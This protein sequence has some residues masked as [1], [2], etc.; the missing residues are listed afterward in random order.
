M[1]S[2]TVKSQNG[3]SVPLKTRL[4]LDIIKHVGGQQV[5]VPVTYKEEIFV[6]DFV[7][8]IERSNEFRD[9]SEQALKDMVSLYFEAAVTARLSGDSVA[10]ALSQSDEFTSIFE[11]MSVRDFMSDR[12]YEAAKAKNGG[13]S[14]SDDEI[15]NN[16]IVNRL[17]MAAAKFLEKPLQSTLFK[18]TLTN[19]E[20]K[21]ESLDQP[22]KFASVVET[23]R[24]AQRLYSMLAQREPLE[25]IGTQCM[26]TRKDDEVLAYIDA[27]RTVFHTGDGAVLPMNYSYVLNEFL[28]V[29]T[30]AAGRRKES[31]RPFLDLEPLSE[32]GIGH[33]YANLKGSSLVDDIPY[34]DLLYAY[35]TLTQMFRGFSIHQLKSGALSIEKLIRTVQYNSGA[36]SPSIDTS[37]F[38]LFMSDDKVTLQE[39]FLMKWFKF[40]L[41]ERII[42]NKPGTIAARFFNNFEM[43]RFKREDAFSGQIT[44]TTAIVGMFYDSLVDTLSFVR[45]ILLDESLFFEDL[46]PQHGPRIRAKIVEMDSLY[47]SLTYGADH[48]KHLMD[49]ALPFETMNLT[50]FDEDQFKIGGYLPSFTLDSGQY[51]KCLTIRDPKTWSVENWWRTSVLRGFTSD[52]SIGEIPFRFLSQVPTFRPTYYVSVPRPSDVMTEPM[53]VKFL[54]FLPLNDVLKSE[55]KE[56]LI[57][58]GEVILLSNHRDAAIKL[59]ISHVLAARILGPN[60]HTVFKLRDVSE[61]VILLA[62]SDYPVYE[63][64]LMPSIWKDA[65]PNPNNHFVALYPFVLQ[66]DYAGSSKGFDNPVTPS[67]GQRLSDI[68]MTKDSEVDESLNKPAP[69]DSKVEEAKDVKVDDKPTVDDEVDLMSKDDVEESDDDKKK[70]KS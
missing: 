9:F 36:M 47:N 25:T 63:T 58:R 42:K 26:T 1:R 51:A 53:I 44:E 52:A 19:R 31:K 27:V 55:F 8:E 46:P 60:P 67:P 22:F 69:A 70:K 59:G 15:L 65:E 28:S 49:P 20:I 68:Q 30:P 64:S 2:L 54:E 35:V 48:P 4:A 29:T 32:S 39:D 6:F 14:P 61:Q 33:S 11:T 38:S 12:D 66:E 56:F 18:V 41:T 24:Y 50:Q 40:F 5:M 3:V 10:T 37:I 21:Q 43:N 13:K 34:R 16:V 62:S 57:D 7:K 45:S 17:D 23:L